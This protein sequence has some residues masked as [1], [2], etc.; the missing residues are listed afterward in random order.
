[1]DTALVGQPLLTQPQYVPLRP[2]TFAQDT[3]S[4]GQR[5]RHM[6]NLIVPDCLC[7]EKVRLEPLYPNHL[8]PAT[9]PPARRRGEAGQVPT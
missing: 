7:P 3:S 2:D 5:L 8:R 4:S 1:M 9:V 6:L